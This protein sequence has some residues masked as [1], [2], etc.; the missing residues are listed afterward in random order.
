MGEAGS[1]ARALAVVGRL[2]PD[3]LVVD[4]EIPGLDA[5]SAIAA[6]RQQTPESAI[7]VVSIEPDR[8]R[9]VTGRDKRVLTIGKIEGADGL[10]S[11]IRRVGSA[12]A[13]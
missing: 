6:L 12:A 11:T 7:V 8:L 4:V 10:L 5:V 13:D 2:R 9:S 1:V 3:V